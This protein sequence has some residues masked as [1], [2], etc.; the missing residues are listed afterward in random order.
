MEDIVVTIWEHRV[1]KA[2]DTY[3]WEFNHIENG[4]TEETQT[5]T[6]VTKIQ[7]NSWKGGMWQKQKGVLINGFHLK[8]I[9]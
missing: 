2:D 3:E 4:Y 5:P 6:P 1:K 7:E 9:L 8:K